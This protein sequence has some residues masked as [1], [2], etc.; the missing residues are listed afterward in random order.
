MRAAAGSEDE[1]NSENKAAV[2]PEEKTEEKSDE[3]ADNAAN[4]QANAEMKSA[5]APTEQAEEKKEDTSA[6][7]A[8]QKTEDTTA[9]QTE[10]KTE[11]TSAQQAEQKKEDTATAQAEEKKEDTSTAQAE[12]KKED[13]SA[14]QA[15][16]KKDDS[17]DQQTPPPPVISAAPETALI[18]TASAIVHWEDAD[19]AN[20]IRPG[21][22]VVTLQKSTDGGATY[23]D[24]ETYTLNAGNDWKVQLEDLT[25][26]EDG[27]EVTYRWDWEVDDTP[28]G[29]LNE[30]EDSDEH[31]LVG[32]VRTQNDEL[33][34]GTRSE[35]T[36]THVLQKRAYTIVIN[37]D[38]AGDKSAVIPDTLDVVLPDGRT[39]TVKASDG[40]KLDVEIPIVHRDLEWSLGAAE[41]W[42]SNGNYTDYDEDSTIITFNRKWTTTTE[43]EPA[44]MSTLKVQYWIGSTEA[45]PMFLGVYENGQTYNVS[46]PK[47]TGYKAKVTR[48]K[49]VINGDTVINVKYV[50]IT[51]NVTVY[52]RYLNGQTAAP[53]AYRSMKTGT[54]YSIGSPA[55]GG[56]AA[57]VSLISG[58]VTGRDLTYVVYYTGTGGGVYNGAGRE[59][60]QMVDVNTI[61][62]YKTPL[63]LGEIGI[64]AGECFE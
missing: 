12:E 33:E 29:S 49:G 15:D 31:N 50:P 13:A 22:M 28:E 52:Y 47:V 60:E 43:I 38:D 53:T 59:E 63:G 23:S 3:I 62:D 20:D 34:D 57:S 9:Q 24:V 35:R 41:G 17:S 4:Q 48:V 46:V 19:D 30:V 8:E 56:Y 54:S 64:N 6:Q 16:T 61:D 10:Q 5:A 40:W 25:G 27:K 11:D 2:N 26:M 7:Q 1:N 36:Y 37:W 42:R 58:T 32:Y 45:A 14:N 55:I 21:F 44:G 18:K 39:V 51:Y